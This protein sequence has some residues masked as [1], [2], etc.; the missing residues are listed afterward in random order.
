[1]IGVTTPYRHVFDGGEKPFTFD[2]STTLFPPFS[3]GF[4][5]AKGMGDASFQGVLWGDDHVS[6]MLHF[7]AKIKCEDAFGMDIPAA[8]VFTYI[9][10]YVFSLFSL[11]FMS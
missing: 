5:L 3:L 6:Y 4:V 2:S 10:P 9:Y 7:D 8:V 11:F 1:M